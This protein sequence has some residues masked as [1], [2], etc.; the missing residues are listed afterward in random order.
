MIQ[1]LLPSEHR[2]A[3]HLISSPTLCLVLLVCLRKGLIAQNPADARRS[4]MPE[5]TNRGRRRTAM[6][7]LTSGRS[8]EMSVNHGKQSAVDFADRSGGQSDRS[9][10]ISTA[11]H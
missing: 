11:S 9:Q 2:R 8:I 4:Y 3:A 6:A 5:R 10:D 1:R 7:S